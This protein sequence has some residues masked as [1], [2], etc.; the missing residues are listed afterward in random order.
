MPGLAYVV[1]KA[2]EPGVAKTRLCPPLSPTAAAQVARA[3][4]QDTLDTVA[5][6]G[7]TSRLICRTAAERDSLRP[8]VG[9]TVQIDVQRGEG[10]GGALESAFSRG[11]EDGHPAVAVLGAD[12][13][14]LPAA[15]LAEGFDAVLGAGT[16]SADVAIGPSEDGGYYFL[17]ARALHRTLFADM[18]WSTDRVTGETLARCRAAGLR[19]LLLPTWYD[20]DDAASLARLQRHLG[21]LPEG[22]AQH[23]RAA[24]SQLSLVTV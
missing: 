24:L 1:A 4:L 12:S 3:F 5:A 8:I 22:V 11:L 9:P 21:S 15:V 2:P 19:T 13:P 23:T 16:C 17:A 10:L 18:P 7:L 14:T 20:V 6:G